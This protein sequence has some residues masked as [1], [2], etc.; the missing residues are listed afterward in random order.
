MQVDRAQDCLLGQ[1]TVL[2]ATCVL[3]SLTHR[4]SGMESWVNQHKAV[5]ERVTGWQI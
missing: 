3:H 2:F 1:L 5:I 4:F